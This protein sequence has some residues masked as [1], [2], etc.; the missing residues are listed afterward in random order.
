MIA[1]KSCVTRPMACMIAAMALAGCVTKV[2]LPQ[3]QALDSLV[4]Q[5]Q[6]E[7]VAEIGKPTTARVVPAGA[8]PAGLELAYAYRSITLQA[9]EIGAPDNPE[10]TLRNH[11]RFVTHSCDT[12]FQIA[13]DRV[14]AWSVNGSDCWQA[15]Y[16]YLG[17]L[18][19]DALARDVKQGGDPVV[20]FL[21]NSR[22]GN[23]LV[24]SGTFQNQ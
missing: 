8:T 1:F 3:R 10:L 17:N 4:G 5:S 24:L 6:A 9:D 15:P 21:F 12:V 14:V 22:T 16:P 19:R 2:T 18:K 7:L 11:A 13:G 23:S 20:P